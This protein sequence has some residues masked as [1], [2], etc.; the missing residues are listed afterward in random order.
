MNLQD[1]KL[2]LLDMD[3][4]IYLGDRLF[5]GTLDFLDQIRKSG[6]RVIF[7][8][9]NSSRFVDRY[10][11]RLKNFG[12]QAGPED[13]FTSSMA[14][15]R[16]LRH[17]NYRKIYV[18]GTAS[19]R[20]ELSDLPVTDR[21]EDDIDCLLLGYDTELHYQKLV[22]ACILLGRE[23]VDYLATNP[24]TVC[25]TSWGYVP[26]CGSIARM[27]ETATGRWPVF[28]GKPQPEMPLLAAEMAGCTPEETV[29]IGDRI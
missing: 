22:D 25:P 17:R 20:A 27:L 2:F 21:L 3:G 8:T 1:K 18:L 9:N 5:D 4:T 6:G 24:D 13:F 10:V 29:V 12:I 26:D 23:G 28:I 19:L 11:E 16:F 14:S 7:L 15:A